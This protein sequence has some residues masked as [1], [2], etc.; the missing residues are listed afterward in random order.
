MRLLL[1]EDN[2]ILSEVLSTA[3]IA[4]G[5]HVDVA[6][7]GET[8]FSLADNATYDLLILD[9]MLPGISGIEL[10]KKIRRSSITAPA[11]FLT[12]RDSVTDRI[13][14]LDSGADDY[15]VKPFSV[16]EL[17]ARIR[18]LLRRPA[19]LK[20]SNILS[21]KDL[22]LDLD[23]C[24]LI[25]RDETFKL[26]ITE[27]NLLALLIKNAGLFVSKE[28]ILNTVWGPFSE[29]EPNNVEIYIHH[30]RKNEFYKK[31]G[32]VIETRRGVGYCLQVKEDV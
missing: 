27:A 21:V 8:G 6:G 15:L 23:R 10:L 4:N 1:V 7:D 28:R 18:A 24:E 17:L 22:K 32:M 13:T 2:T 30:L 5:Y 31:M 26:S 12:A 19:Y 11:I 25:V 3:L 14:G 29:I 20:R 9:I 16:D